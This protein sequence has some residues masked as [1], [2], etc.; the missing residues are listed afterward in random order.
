MYF[1][2]KLNRLDFTGQTMMSS[3]VPLASEASQEISL[4]TRQ[5]APSGAEQKTVAETR[6]S[7]PSTLAAFRPLPVGA[8]RPAGR[9][10]LY[11]EEQASNLGSQLPQVSDLAW[12][13]GYLPMVERP[14]KEAGI[15]RLTKNGRGFIN[16]GPV[17]CRRSTGC[18]CFALFRQ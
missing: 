18:G 5:R 10:R 16:L 8:K 14:E 7:L 12:T 6:P 13:R 2:S 17:D 4:K 3:E 9:P 11:L 15:L 1:G